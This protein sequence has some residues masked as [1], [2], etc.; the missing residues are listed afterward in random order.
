[1][2]KERAVPH[3]K[4]KPADRAVIAG[5][6]KPSRSSVSRLFCPP[7]AAFK[8]YRFLVILDSRFAVDAVIGCR[9]RISVFPPDTLKLKNLIIIAERARHPVAPHIRLFISRF[10]P[11]RS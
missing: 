5:Q 6:M 2:R 8:H 10:D 11:A 7:L 1:M 3:P 9:F 4:R